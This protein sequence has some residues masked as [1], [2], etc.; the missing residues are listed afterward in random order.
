MAFNVSVGGVD[1]AN[2]T[3]RV[4]FGQPVNI[5]STSGIHRIHAVFEIHA[6]TTAAVQTLWQATK[7]AFQTKDERVILTYD[8]TAG[9]PIE[10][11]QQG[12]NGYTNIITSVS[13][14][15]GSLSTGKSF[16]GVLDIVAE[17]DEE[18]GL[19]GQVGEI[20]MTKF[21]S[22]GNVE[23]RTV[24]ATFKTSDDGATT[25]L[26]NYAA[27]RS[28]IFTTYV[29]CDADG[30]RDATTGL[31][32]IDENINTLDEDALLVAVTIISSEVVLDY[33]AEPSLRS[34]DLIVQTSQPDAW[35]EVDAGP[36][37]TLITAA[38]KVTVD[39]DVLSG[40]LHDVFN[41]IRSAME[42]EVK[43]QSGKSDIELV[44][45][46]VSSDRLA[47]TMS[48]SAVYRADN[49]ETFIY[50]RVDREAEQPQFNSVVDADG[51]E[52]IQKRPGA[53]PIV[54]TITINR[55]G[56]GLGGTDPNFGGLDFDL[57]I[58]NLGHYE[59]I[60]RDEALEGPITQGDIEGIYIQQ[61]TFVYKRFDPS[62]SVE[63]VKVGI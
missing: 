50:R 56:V 24:T 39:K 11:I 12:K 54:R 19:A 46:G 4:L 48:F 63:I 58:R 32:R 6:A 57:L 23:G 27:A 33:S 53:N 7:A 34:N 31:A 18:D 30:G 41:T 28:T 29:G 59:L 13:Q 37:P 51:V 55:T 2:G 17:F 44:S 42:T 60:H 43:S 16:K 8:D 62:V 1:L 36:I 47:S 26:A 15:G 40:N 52:I 14:T 3:S 9:D 21:F 45:L 20:S 49:V 61:A 35:P 10:D 38:G 25:A 5:R 22:A